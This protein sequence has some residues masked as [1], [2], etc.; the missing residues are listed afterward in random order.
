[1]SFTTS[2]SGD[3]DRHGD[4]LEAMARDL[5]QLRAKV[6]ELEARSRPPTRRRAPPGPASVSAE[7]SESTSG[8]EP[9]STGRYS[10][11]RR[12]LFGLLGSAAAAGAGLT[13]AGSIAGPSTASA[14]GPD[15][16]LANGINGTGNDA[17]TAATSIT[18]TAT[19]ATFQSYNTISPQL[20]LL[21]GTLSGSPSGLHSAGD[22]FADEQGILWYATA[23]GNPATWVPLSLPPI[24]EP[25]TPAPVRVYDSRAGYPPSDVDKGQLQTNEQR[26]IDLSHGGVLNLTGS[27]AALVNLTVVN[28]NGAGYVAIFAAD[29][30]WPGN[31]NI[32]W[33]AS[34]QILA[35]NAT[36]LFDPSFNIKALNGGPPTDLVIDVMGSYLG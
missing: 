24:F 22:V 25:I 26:T 35:N 7:G 11:S 16:A 6:E 8:T 32:N 31:S 2:A 5:A 9:T 1:M 27:Y 34:N 20:S 33:F 13:V 10:V 36:S 12:R 17:G 23:S 18:S 30:A 3:Q 15:V 19:S 4:R 14:D 29:V 28:T 21:G